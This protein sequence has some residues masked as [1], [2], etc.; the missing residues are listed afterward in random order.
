[1]VL[2]AAALPLSQPALAAGW[3]VIR[4]TDFL[5][6]QVVNND[7][8]VLGE[9]HELA[10]DARSGRVHYVVLEVG[11]FLGIN[12]K[13]IPYPVSALSPG[14]GDARVVLDVRP[15]QLAHAAGFPRDRWPAWTDRVWERAD[16]PRPTRFLRARE[17][18]GR[19]VQ[20]RG[21]EPIGTAAGPGSE[22]GERRSARQALVVGS[23]ERLI[24]FQQVQ[25]PRGPGLPVVVRADY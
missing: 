2:L 9:V 24:P 23:R 12:E 15:E 25:P 21:G 16:A 3:E 10:I 20:D 18:I 6:T 22:P 8:E 17:L 7:G 5:D 13:L 19:T 11:G 1:V 4:A 14:P